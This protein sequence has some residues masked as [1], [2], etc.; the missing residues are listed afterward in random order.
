VLDGIRHN[1]LF[2]LSHPEFRD[3]LT[4]RSALLL[5]SLPDEPLNQARAD[6][7]RWLLSNPVYE[8]NT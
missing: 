5:G 6:S 2:I 4:A 8:K 7:A 1:R 3:V